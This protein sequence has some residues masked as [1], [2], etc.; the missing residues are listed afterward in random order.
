MGCGIRERNWELVVRDQGGC[1][2]TARSWGFQALGEAGEHAAEFVA[3]ALDL[4]K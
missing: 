2:G 1:R 4:R 3:E